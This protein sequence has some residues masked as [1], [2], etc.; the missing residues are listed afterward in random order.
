MIKNSNKAIS[1]KFVSLYKHRRAINTVMFGLSL[2]K[3]KQTIFTSASTLN[4][5]DLKSQEWHRRL[6]KIYGLPIIHHHGYVCELPPNHRFPMKKFH[7][8]IDYLV[9][10]RVIDRN[11]QVLEPDQ[12]PMAIAEN[13][14][15]HE[16]VD[17]F[18][19]GKTTEN[20]Q[21][22]TGFV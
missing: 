12:I 9:S 18:F 20:E 7:K 19:N 15:S 22:A 4:K 17:N 14:H 10:D 3:C 13:V 8:V 16:Y 11:K 6:D 2:T 21:R 1:E 5:I